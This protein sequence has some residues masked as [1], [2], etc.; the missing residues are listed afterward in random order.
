VTADKAELAEQFATFASQFH[1]QPTVERTIDVVAASARVALGCDDAGILLRVNG[2]LTTASA[3]S[4]RVEISDAVQIESGEGPCFAAAATPQIYLV[5]DTT[6]S[7]PWPDWARVV[8]DLGIRSA[9][10]VPLRTH[11]RNY[12]ALN[13][14]SDAPGTF[15]DD[16]VAI[17]LIFARHASVAL[18]HAT[19]A[20]TLTQAIDARKVIGQAQGI[21]MERYGLD[22][23]TAFDTLMRFSQDHNM[24]LR[25][26]ADHIVAGREFPPR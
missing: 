17:A 21:V 3:T 8:S 18:D 22:S 20:H 2:K 14:Y 12:G 16:E 4:S 25:Q 23:D 10:G 6:A 19:K 5:E 15:G 1:A 11:D 26:L 24:K 9:V 13:L 7:T